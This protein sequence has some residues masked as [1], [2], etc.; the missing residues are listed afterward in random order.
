MINQ[1]T[2][3]ADKLYACNWE[4]GNHNKIEIKRFIGESSSG[5]TFMKFLIFSIARS[6]KPLQITALKFSVLSLQSF[7]KILSTSL[8]YFTLL[9][10]LVEK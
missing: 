5:I 1:S 3:T 8:S 10:T 7:T 2:K 9:Q 6:Q 4:G